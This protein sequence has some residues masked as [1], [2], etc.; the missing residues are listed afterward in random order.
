MHIKSWTNA[1]PFHSLAFWKS[2]L[3]LLI[4]WPKDAPWAKK[5]RSQVDASCSQSI[6]WACGAGEDRPFTIRRR[7][8]RTMRKTFTVARDR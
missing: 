6:R 1:I 3:M 4:S 7:T 5:K 8:A 2:L